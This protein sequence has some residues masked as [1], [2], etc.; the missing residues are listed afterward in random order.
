MYKVPMLRI[1]YFTSTWA[2]TEWYLAMIQNNSLPIFLAF[3]HC[4]NI[5]CHDLPILVDSF[6]I[7]PIDPTL[8]HRV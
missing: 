2:G 6:G 1:T 3:I 8:D 7:N 4:G 5:F